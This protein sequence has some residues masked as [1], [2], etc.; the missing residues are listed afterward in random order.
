MAAAGRRA[1]A[2]TTLLTKGLDTA[3]PRVLSD[4][5]EQT[6]PDFIAAPV[7]RD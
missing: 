6:P 4:R 7:G 3:A 1:D 2:M 5:M